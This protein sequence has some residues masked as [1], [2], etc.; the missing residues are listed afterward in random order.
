MGKHKTEK[1]YK[2]EKKR[3]KHIKRNNAAFK[4]K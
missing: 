4:K 1:R 3:M 2:T